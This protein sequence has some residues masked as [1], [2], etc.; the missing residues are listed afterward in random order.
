MLFR[1][2][3]RRRALW[4]VQQLHGHSLPLLDSLPQQSSATVI[5]AA[6]P[7]L[8]VGQ[9]YAAVGLSLKAHPVSFIRKELCAKGVITAAQVKDAKR[10]PTGRFVTVAGIVLF[11]QRPGTA[12]GVMFMTIEDE[13]GR[14][15][16]IVRPQIYERYRNA[17]VY[18]GLVLVRGKIERQGGVVHVL[19]S[20]LEEIGRA[21]V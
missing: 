2:L 9:D 14:A 5:P 17:A 6:P 13:T 11:R 21:H 4:E 1:S 10:T 12:K 7:A 8:D 19:A 20:A 16:L 15:D 3:D 18:A